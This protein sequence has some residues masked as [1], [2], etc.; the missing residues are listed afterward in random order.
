MKNRLAW[1]IAL[2]GYLAGLAMIGF[3]PTP[4]DKPIQG[5][6]SAV[7]NYL[8]SLGVP[9]WIGYNFVEASANVLLFIP[10]GGLVAFVLP[11]KPWWHVAALSALVSVS[12]EGGQLLFITDRFFSLLDLVTNALGAVIGIAFAR[13]FSRRRLAESPSA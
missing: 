1:R 10:L 6:L 3:W 12:M 7:L 13:L 11:A 9:E 4:V 8:H 2:A 5:T